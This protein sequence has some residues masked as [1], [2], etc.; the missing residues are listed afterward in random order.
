VEAFALTYVEESENAL[1]KFK[2]NTFS[3]SKLSG[4]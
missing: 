4:D 3:F 2:G 1:L